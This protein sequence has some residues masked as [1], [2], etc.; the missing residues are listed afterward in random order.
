MCLVHIQA[1]ENSIPYVYMRTEST[2]EARGHP[3]L[4]FDT[5][6]TC[7]CWRDLQL[8]AGDP[9]ITGYQT[10][11][12]VY[13]S[14]RRRRRRRR[15]RRALPGVPQ[16]SWPARHSQRRSQ[17]ARGPGPR[18][19]AGSLRWQGQRALRVAAAGARAMWLQARGRRAARRTACRAQVAPPALPMATHLCRRGRR[20][21][22]HARARFACT[23]GARAVR[24]GARTI[25]AQHMAHARRCMAHALRTAHAPWARSSSVAA[26]VAVR[27]CVR[28]VGVVCAQ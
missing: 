9:H 20:C 25:M 11:A 26:V 3:I 24:H 12:A 18:S 21:T 1:C 15:G 10:A 14:L 19:D 7:G 13:E 2:R 16:V 27:T 17:G 6:I 23:R 4:S 5:L 22:W 28:A 8:G